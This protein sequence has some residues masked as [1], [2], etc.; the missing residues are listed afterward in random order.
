[1]N[2]LIKKIIDK[3][4]L[5]KIVEKKYFYL[6]IYVSKKILGLK[7]DNK[8]SAGIISLYDPLINL[9]NVG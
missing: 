6:K 2:Y 5:K 9:I 8:K 3:I 1:M 4:I 7:L